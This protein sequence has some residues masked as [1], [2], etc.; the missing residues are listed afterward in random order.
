MSPELRSTAET[1]EQRANTRARSIDTTT[2]QFWDDYDWIWMLD[3][4]SRSVGYPV[5]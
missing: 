3:E 2:R 4:P 5:R 1:P